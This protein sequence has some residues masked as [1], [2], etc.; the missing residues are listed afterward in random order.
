MINEKVG[1]DAIDTNNESIQKIVGY[2]PTFSCVICLIFALVLTVL[3]VITK[4]YN[5]GYLLLIAAF[6]IYPIFIFV[7]VK[8][9]RTISFYETFMLLHDMDNDNLAIKVNYDEIEEWDT[10]K[11]ST[12]RLLVDNTEIYKDTLQINKV[13]KFLNKRLR[14]KQTLEVR[15]AKERNI[16][17]K[18][19]IP[20]IFRRKK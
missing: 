7:T 4:S 15:R 6:I 11:G 10:L 18:W 16:E 17:H 13:Q 20:K 5:A 3:M 19:G 12:L 9:K 1:L 8:D 14:E 2:R